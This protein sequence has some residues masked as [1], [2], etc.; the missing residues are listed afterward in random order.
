MDGDSL[1]FPL[2]ESV[3]GVIFFVLMDTE[4]LSKFNKHFQYL[5]NYF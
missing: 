1:G 4:L 3:C 5:S 2:Q